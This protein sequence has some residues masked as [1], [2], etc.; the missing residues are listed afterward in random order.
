LVFKFE[1]REEGRIEYMGGKGRGGKEWE[2]EMM[3]GKGMG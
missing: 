3:E 1:E 2:R